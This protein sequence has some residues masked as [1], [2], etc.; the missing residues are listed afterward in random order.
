[1]STLLIPYKIITILILFVF[2]FFIS[3]FRKKEKMK[4]LYSSTII[5]L[6]K[7][8]YLVPISIF[9]YTVIKIQTLLLYD[10][11]LPFIMCIGAFL[12]VKSK[13]DLGHHHTWVGYF[14]ENPGFVC[15]GIYSY[16]RHPLY[17]GIYIIIIFCSVSI[18]IHNPIYIGI[19]NAAICLFIL[20]FIFISAHK[21]TSFLINYH[22]PEFEKYCKT[23]HPFFP[24]KKWR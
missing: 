19:L 22:G 24:L 6:L 18:A 11:I 9:I 5:I 4:P 14:S 15:K 1:M 3:D 2:A 12:V 13:L 8:L 7:V 23:I 10:Y 16:I 21:E 20:G 17:A